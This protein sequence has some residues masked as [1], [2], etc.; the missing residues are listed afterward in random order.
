MEIK[1]V[2]IF[3]K[4][5]LPSYAFFKCSTE[6]KS[7]GYLVTFTHKAQGKKKK[8]VILQ[9]HIQPTD[10]YTK[11]KFYRLVY[12][13]F[14]VSAIPHDITMHYNIAYWNAMIYIL[15][16]FVPTKLRGIPFN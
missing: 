14:P 9:Y 8:K 2:H 6:K 11:E 7:A 10:S 12:K 16:I 5:K 3:Q 1:A 4:I 13:R 15:V